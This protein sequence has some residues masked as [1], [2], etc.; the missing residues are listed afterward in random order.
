[1]FKNLLMNQVHSQWCAQVVALPP[2]VLPPIQLMI[3][4]AKLPSC[5]RGNIH[6]SPRRGVQVREG[7]S[8]PVLALIPNSFFSRLS[9]TFPPSSPNDYRVTSAISRAGRSSPRVPSYGR[10][11]PASTRSSSG[12]SSRLWAKLPYFL[13]EMLDQQQTP[14]SLLRGS[15]RKLDVREAKI[16]QL[17]EEVTKEKKVSNLRVLLQ[18]LIQVFDHPSIILQFS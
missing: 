15:P 2:R 8:G 13:E 6:W 5:F 14:P 11:D 7:D 16:K 3:P 1:M 17:R 4:L 10:R 18:Q 9:S 12:G